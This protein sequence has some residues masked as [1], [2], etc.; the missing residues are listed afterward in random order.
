ML[1]LLL[2]LAGFALLV[3]LLTRGCGWAGSSDAVD[4]DLERTRAEIAA[5]AGRADHR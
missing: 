3:F 4:R 5:I 2:A 1:T